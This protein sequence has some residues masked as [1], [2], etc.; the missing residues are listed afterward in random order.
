MDQSGDVDCLAIKLPSNGEQV[1]VKFRQRGVQ[2]K[3][4]GK[5]HHR[6]L[7]KWFHDSNVPPWLRD[8]VP[9]LYYNKDLVA[10]GDLLVAD[11]FQVVGSAGYLEIKWG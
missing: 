7:K 4:V 1:A 5:A 9:L 2:F 8:S 11:G 6:P 10:V 3:P